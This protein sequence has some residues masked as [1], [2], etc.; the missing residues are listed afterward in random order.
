MDRD[1]RPLNP[2]AHAA[3]HDAAIEE[4][5][6]G[7]E[8]YGIPVLFDLHTGLRKRLLVHYDDS[9]RE[10]T[11]NGE[12]IKTPKQV[13]CTIEEDGCRYCH[14][15][16]SGGP[17]GFLRPKTGQGEQR[18]I[19]IFETW[20]DTYNGGE[21]DTKLKKWLDHWF[22]THDAGWGYK[23]GSVSDAVFH[24]AQR[25]HD[26]LVKEHQGAVE[27]YVCGT[28]KIV[29]NIIVHDLRASFATQCLRT[30]IDDAT[31]MDWCGWQEPEMLNHYRGFIGDPDG[32]GRENYNSGG[33][34][35]STTD[36][37][38]FMAKEGMLDSEKVDEEA[39]E[40]L[41]DQL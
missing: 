14:H 20:Y 25:R 41:S 23:R 39:L 31:V 1:A 40:T 12:Q 26:V 15:D 32:T 8:R 24:V 29:P 3:M 18:T 35:L 19:P 11:E 4:I 33:D 28:K 9:W 21:R 16:R 10:H 5:H 22:R 36:L 2:K 37:I 27:R 6:Q 30:K 17:D 13:L 38:Q 7:N 34:K